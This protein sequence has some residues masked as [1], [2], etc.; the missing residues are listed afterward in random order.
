VNLVFFDGELIFGSVCNMFLKHIGSLKLRMK[1]RSLSFFPHTVILI[2]ISNRSNICT[3]NKIV[4]ATL[5]FLP[6]FFHELNSK[7]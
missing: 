1:Y 6:Q 5:L 4:N 2:D 3:M 7:I